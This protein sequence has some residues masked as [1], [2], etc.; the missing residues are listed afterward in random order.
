MTD[1]EVEV[2]KVK[3]ETALFHSFLA[4]WKVSPCRAQSQDP[5][6][7]HKVL[8]ELSAWVHYFR[9]VLSGNAVL[10]FS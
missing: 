1:L 4:S 9:R 2:L 8:L 7:F 3:A 5:G 10:A 6:L